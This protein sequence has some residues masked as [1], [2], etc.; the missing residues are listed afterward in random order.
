MFPKNLT[1]LREREK[2]TQTELARRINVTR[3][4]IYMYERG[5]RQPSVGI[6]EALMQLFG[7]TADELLFGEGT[8]EETKGSETQ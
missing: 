2:M 4:A 8:A 5:T 1:R 3:G 6:I 7:C